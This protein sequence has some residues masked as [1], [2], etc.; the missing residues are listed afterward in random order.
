MSIE[1]D[2]NQ[3][4]T[5]LKKHLKQFNPIIESLLDGFKQE[6][7]S[8]ENGKGISFLS[9]KNMLIIEYLMN[10]LNL[11]YLKTNG[12]QL[13]G[14]PCVLR[15]AELRCVLE[16][17]KSIEV[18]LKYQIDKLLK[19]ATNIGTDEQHPLSFKANTDDFGKA[20]SG[21]DEEDDEDI[22]RKDAED[23]E[24]ESNRK[25]GIY[26][27]SK[28]APVYNDIDQTP[29]DRARR[30]IERLKRRALSGSIMKEI[31][32]EYSGAPEEIKDSYANTLEME[33]NEHKHRIEYEEENFVRKP[34]TKNEMSRIKRLKR[35]TNL[36]SLTSFDDARLLLD[37]NINAEDF[38]NKRKEKKKEAKGKKGSKK[39]Q[40][41]KK[42]IRYT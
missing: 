34:L 16:K 24:E 21:D 8:I 15:L 40:K 1:N 30:E 11:T 37:D 22:L 2:L 12:K 42:K 35:G 29:E 39:N 32:N 4:N 19:M 25:D 23:D 41:K 14:S 20:E 26:R 13:S 28:L 36:D 27:P 17:T 18:K 6:P 10:L 31:E 38:L 33:S 5:D 3:L 9:M 7:E